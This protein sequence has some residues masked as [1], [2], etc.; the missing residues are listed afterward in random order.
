MKLRN[1]V[2]CHDD[3]TFRAGGFQIRKGDFS[4]FEE[5]ADGVDLQGAY[6]IPGLIDIHL[7]GSVGVDFSAASL[8]GLMKI[9]EYLG[10]N[11]I[12]SFVPT[13]MTL[14]EETLKTAF[15]TAVKY[16]E[17]N[18]SGTARL[19]GI[20]ME[21]PFL[22]PEKN[23]AQAA[24][25]LRLP[26]VGMFERLYQASEGLLKIVCIAPELPGAM[27]F[28]CR[29]KDRCR[30]SVGHTDADY[31]AACKAFAAGACQVTHLY[32]GMPPFLHRA[33]GV[34]GAAAEAEPVS[35]EL[36]C[37][38]YHVHESVI[39]ATFS[40]FSAD[41]II[42]VS[43]SL[44]CLGMP[45]GIY[46]SGGTKVCRKNGFAVLE[47][48][49][50]FAG[51][52]TNLFQCVRKAIS[53]GIRPEDAIKAATINP[54]KAVGADDRVGSITLGKAA[55]FVVCDKDFNIIQCYIGGNQV[56]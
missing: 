13:S 16:H 4:S 6:V 12:T 52:D 9:A 49:V 32:N 38:G 47:D 33:P 23:G 37:D 35:A 8:P 14:P 17:L 5:A 24:A 34:V 56:L 53:F 54:A 25:H 2:I 1:A 21:G 46:E 45:E 7:H 31:M 30:V 43:D 50:T 55:D 15:E 40:M 27:D 26:D 3:F 28:I 22:S 20:H 44:S 29:V 41:R 42:L 48:G 18:L 39:R 51:S 19:L 10:R 36:I 11:G